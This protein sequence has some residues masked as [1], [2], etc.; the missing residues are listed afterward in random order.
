M[1]IL[2]PIY[3]TQILISARVDLACRAVALARLNSVKA[4]W[5]KAGKHQRR[6]PRIE[7]MQTD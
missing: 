5:R 6:L 4:A 7:R 1:E 2:Q 3:E